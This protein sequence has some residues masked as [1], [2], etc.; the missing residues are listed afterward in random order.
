MKWRQQVKGLLFLENYVIIK[1]KEG[2]NMVKNIPAK[3]RIL[4]LR[5]QA[6][7]NGGITNER[8]ELADN[9]KDLIE[10]ILA[11]GNRLE[12]KRKIVL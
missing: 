12:R 2:A 11:A 7:N 3:E 10:R 6:K 9:E 4:R 8:R 1:A 5:E